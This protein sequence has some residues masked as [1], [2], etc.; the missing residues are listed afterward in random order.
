M[1][2]GICLIAALAALGI[3]GCAKLPP[4]SDR[5]PSSALA[6][7]RN[8]VLTAPIR[9]ALAEH[10]GKSGVVLL[11]SGLDALVARAVLAEVAQ[12]SIDAQY[13][14]LHNDLTGRYFIY[15]L[16]KA[17]DRGVRV[18]LLLDDMAI[19]GSD[20]NA[21][22]LDTHP[23]IEVRIINP[24]SRGQSRL[25]QF[26]THLG[27]V[28]R[29]MHNKSFT[30]DN[31]V[32]IL[33]GRNIG[34]EYFD[35]DPDV[36]FNDLDAMGFGPFVPEVSESFDRYWNNE[37]SYPISSLAREKLTPERLLE[38]RQR[39]EDN[40]EANRGSAYAQAMSDSDLARGLRAGKLKVHFG[41]AVVLYDQPD[42]ISASRD[43]VEYRLGNEL[44]PYIEGIKS[45]LIVVSPYFVPGEEGVALFSELVGRGVRVIIL[46][47]A[48]S[49]TDVSMVHAGYARYRVPLLRAGVELYELNTQGNSQQGSKRNSIT[50]SSRASLHAKSFV[51]DREKVFIGSMNL[52]PRSLIENS[53]IG[54]IFTSADEVAPM[55]ARLDKWITE[56]AFRVELHSDPWVADRLVWHGTN[57]GQQVT[58][59]VDPYT[60]AWNRF[61]VDFF[62][63]LPI[64]SQL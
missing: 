57:N 3:S 58:H 16:L 10:P 39:L 5:Q 15:Q 12:T 23:N 42:K 40:V 51:I 38:L 2:R 4:N 35:A 64:D 26:V 45:E 41:E 11:P 55:A 61:V 8:S 48:L 31:L 47:N 22:A 28:T 50:G 19:S 17:A 21:A 9:K 7:T 30:V 52:D 29:R 25:T 37:L 20:E 43:K 36:D 32:S 33:G 27:S 54:M 14:L 1:N 56:A 34:N 6:D 63:L 44:R 60:S 62:S 59:Y 24:F 18:R 53:E 49:S 46:T 13:Y